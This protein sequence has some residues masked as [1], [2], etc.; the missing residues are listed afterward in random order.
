VPASSGVGLDL[1]S[2]TGGEL[3]FAGRYRVDGLLG[4]GGMGAVYRALDVLVGDRVALKILDAGVDAAHLELFR[5]EVRLARRISHPNIARTH[6]MGEHR[7]APYLTMELVEGRTL[8]QL[9]RE[10]PGGLPPREAAQIL[11]GVCEGLAAAHAAGVVHR[12]LKP[13]NIMIE[14]EGRV[15]LTD[16]GI[17]RR[18]D[19]VGGSQAILGTPLYMAPEQ[20]EGRALDA[21]VDLYAAGL[22]LFEALTGELPFVGE[23]AVAVALARLST[24]P[25]DILSLKPDLP[26]PLVQAVRG[27]LAADPGRRPESAGRLAGRLAAWLAAAAEALD[28]GSAAAASAGRPRF[29]DE[30]TQRVVSELL[31][32]KLAVLPIRGQGA[33]ELGYLG[34]VVSEGLIDVLA[35]TGGLTVLGSGATAAYRERRDPRVVGADLGVAL[36]VDAALL[37]APTQLKLQAR[38]VEVTSGVQVW[39]ERLDARYEDDPIAAAEVLWQRL[40]EALRVELILHAHRGEAGP[41]ALAMVRRARRKIAGGHYLGPDGAL[42][43]LEESLRA[44]PLFVPALALHA[45][46][47][48][49]SWFFVNRASGDRDWEAFARASVL[50]AVERAPTLA[51]TEF[52]RGLLAVQTGEWQEAARAF[53]RALG[54][55]P[56]YA[57][58]HE[59]LSQL[60]LEAGN[61]E[62]GIAR[63]RLAAALEPS[64]LPALV[65]VARVHALR[66]ELVEFAGVIAQLQ[67]QPHFQFMALVARARVG[68]WYG[69]QAAVREAFER[70]Q[71][72]TA[73]GQF[74]VISFIARGYLG[75]AERA[76]LVASARRILDAGPS[77]RLY[78]TSCQVCAEIMAARGFLE[79]ALDMLELA[80]G[81]RLI[82]IDWLDHCPP[83]APLREHPRLLAVRRQVTARVE[84]MWIV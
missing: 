14:D 54:L 84:M 66:G 22:V 34:E 79:E 60:Q 43:L 20:L 6:D 18:I 61:L 26:E 40:A 5:S 69:D 8:Q 55:A 19:E 36:V 17:A 65:H 32:P 44:A 38:L 39:S 46:V 10:Q 68:G 51:E 31:A 48:A 64:L 58:A 75:L 27:C 41:E 83:L 45:V 16:F 67:R 33:P 50:R 9:L 56:A 25:R 70:A 15:V 59:Y 82:D 23:S 47:S 80:C 78:T 13:A 7:G 3:L 21:R 24:P 37:V 35:R 4:R 53:V 42:E 62:E 29:G 11:V 72:L 2:I 49:R 1:T 30:A 77:P 12:D 28:A 73:P 76:E 57:H 74:G 81:A 52:A 71:G 63:A